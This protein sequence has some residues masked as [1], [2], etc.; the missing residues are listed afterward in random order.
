MRDPG[1]K[2][3]RLDQ[4]FP[5]LRIPDELVAFLFLNTGESTDEQYSFISMLVV[6]LDIAEHE[7]VSVATHHALDSNVAE[8][9]FRMRGD[10]VVFTF[11][12]MINNV[13]GNAILAPVIA[14]PLHAALIGA[15]DDAAG[16]R[17]PAEGA[18]VR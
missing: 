11:D 14:E 3:L 9:S 13:R 15:L 12:E 18:G 1:H 10:L 4:W 6:N 8:L 7:N 16:V 2:F 5:C 17:E